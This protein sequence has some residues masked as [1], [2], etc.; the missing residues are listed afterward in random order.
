MID[1]A[2]LSVIRRWHVREGVSIREISRR[3]KLS[4][5]TIRKHLAN[6]ALEAVYPK[7]RS[8]SKV[9]GYAELLAS[10]LKRESARGR[11]ER[12]NLKQLHGELMKLGYTGSYDRV[13]AF[14]RVWRRQQQEASKVSR[15]TFVPLVF[16]PGEAFQFDWSEDWVVIGGERT[17]LMVAQF[18]LCH[19]RAFMLRAYPRGPREG[20]GG[21]RPVQGDG[22]PFPVRSGVL[23]AWRRMGERPDREERPGRAA[24]SVP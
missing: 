3:T 20:P 22:E 6:G 13:A 16:A 18:K 23:H 9:D 11:K 5:N 21:Q 8:R 19:S 4:R 1:V 17:K 12:R 2:I 24:P 14:A 7:R 10:W 15:D